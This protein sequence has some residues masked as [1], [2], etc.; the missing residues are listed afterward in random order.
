MYP[1][2]THHITIRGNRRNVILRDEEDF[3]VYLTQL[4][5]NIEYYNNEYEILCYCLMDNHVHLL[6][7]TYDRHMKFFMKRINSIYP[8]YFNNKYNY[9]GHQR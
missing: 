3:E 8:R 2:T 6:L 7:N 9:C 5:G 1:N 4:Q